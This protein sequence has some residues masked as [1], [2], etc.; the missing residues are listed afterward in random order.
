MAVRS[1]GHH[2]AG[3]GTNNGGLVI[4]VRRL[5]RIEI[6]SERPRAGATIR[7]G[8]GATWGS[9]AQTLSPPGLAISS[10]DTASVGVGG[11][12]GGGG[13]GWMVRRHG[14]A[15]DAV[16]AA[17]VVT[18]DGNLRRVDAHTEPELFWGVRGAAGNLG[19]VTAYEVTA[20]HQPTVLFG[21]LMYPAEQARQVLTGWTRYLP[22][23]PT[24][25]TSTFVL[26]PSMVADGNA[27]AMINI[28]FAGD[29]ADASNVLA[30]LRSVGTVIKDTI[31]SMPYGD[32]L[33]TESMPPG[34]V[35][36]IRNGLVDDWSPHRTD[37]LIDGHDQ[38]PAMAVEVRAIGGALNRTDAA[39]TAF[40]HRSAQFMIN[41]VLVGT[42]AQQQPHLPAFARLSDELRPDGI[43]GNFLSHPTDADTDLCYPEPTRSRLAAVKAT[44][45]PENVF[46]STVNV[47]PATRGRR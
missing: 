8:T 15:I 9:V 27:P 3:F 25:L 6:L 29:P 44:Y 41:T 10:G 12:L 31:T 40:A 18:A 22:D 46:C 1:A 39:A 7:I 4:D 16:S 24:E 19:V 34:F 38:I 37:L 35:P 17:E 23:A 30:P 20:V 21:S 26:P 32:V 2:L 36:R 45:D 43:Y 11:L 47:P 42:P 14:L 28:C 13:I 5:N 33:T